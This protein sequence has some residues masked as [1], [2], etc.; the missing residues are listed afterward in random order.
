[1]ENNDLENQFHVFFRL[2]KLAG[3][4]ES[5]FYNEYRKNGE[6]NENCTL[7]DFTE[8]MRNSDIVVGFE[9]FEEVRKPKL[10]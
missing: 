1:M 10:R 8:W 2:N 5:V 3:D 7:L 6:F 4:I 9:D